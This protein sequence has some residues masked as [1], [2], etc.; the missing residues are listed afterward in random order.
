[1][2]ETDL[3]SSLPRPTNQSIIQ[4]REAKNSSVLVPQN[5]K[6]RNNVSLN[7]HQTNGP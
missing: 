5:K 2:G 1:M 6:H 3:T 7:M 4:Q